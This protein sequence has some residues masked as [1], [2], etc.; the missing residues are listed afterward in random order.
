MIRPAYDSANN[1]FDG[2]VL[3]SVTLTEIH[4]TKQIRTVELRRHSHSITFPKINWIRGHH[5]L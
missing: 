3:K 5:Q 4:K 1:F 2:T